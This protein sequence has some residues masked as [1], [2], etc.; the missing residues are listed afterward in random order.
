MAYSGH[1]QS[2]MVWE[3]NSQNFEFHHANVF[4]QRYN[5]AGELQAR[6]YNFPFASNSFDFILLASVFTHMYP[7]DVQHY[8]QEIAR[9]LRPSGRVLATF[10]LLNPEQRALA[11]QGRNQ[12]DFRFEGDGFRARDDAIPESAVAVEERAL[13]RMLKTARLA[14]QEPIRFGSWS[15]RVDG[16]SH[17]DLVL[18]VP[19]NQASEGRR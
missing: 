8:L 19:A 5:P 11:E 1:F 10:F 3:K 12:I 17:P 7:A 2:I 13:Y 18:I 6:A 15:G 4:N 16:L 9:M 14:I